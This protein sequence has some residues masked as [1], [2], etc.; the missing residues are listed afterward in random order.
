MKSYKS[1]L[2]LETPQQPAGQMQDWEVVK[3]S[4]S[5]MRQ[6]WVQI[7]TQLLLSKRVPGDSLPGFLAPSLTPGR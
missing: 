2:A 5:R 4:H 1:F 7:Q 3:S 6:M